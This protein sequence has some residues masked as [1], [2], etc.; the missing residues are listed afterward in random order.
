MGFSFMSNID[1]QR[2]IN[3]PDYWDQVA[4]EGAEYYASEKEN[5]V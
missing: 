5:N 1:T 2:L 4:P 3:D